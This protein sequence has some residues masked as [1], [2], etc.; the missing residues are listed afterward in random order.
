MPRHISLI[1]AAKYLT[2]YIIQEICVAKNNYIILLDLF[3]TN[4]RFRGIIITV[5]YRQAERS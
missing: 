1:I 3:L 4:T 5:R 2:Y